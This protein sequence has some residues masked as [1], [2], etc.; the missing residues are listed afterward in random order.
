ML[1]VSDSAFGALADQSKRDWLVKAVRTV[2]GKHPQWSA[3]Q[4][5]DSLVAL[6]RR[7][8]DFS[9]EFD[10]KKQ[11]NFEVLV[12]L[13]VET[14]TVLELTAFQR[15]VMERS[16]FTEDNAVSLLCAD[17]RRGSALRLLSAAELGFSLS[18]QEQLA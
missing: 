16:G 6:C 7:L 11:E 17:V 9:A 4:S 3:Q 10:L 2:R 14:G 8:D 13:V 5:E 15:Y 12:D 18:E 1:T